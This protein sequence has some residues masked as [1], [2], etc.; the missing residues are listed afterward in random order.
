MALPGP[1]LGALAM[2]LL[3]LLLLTL[4]AGARLLWDKWK[5]RSLHLPPLVPGFLHLLQPN[6]PLYLLG[7]TQKLGPVYRLRLGLRGALAPSPP[8]QGEEGRIGVPSLL[9]SCFGHPPDVVVLNSKRT[10]EEAMIRK[11]VDFAGRPQTASCKC[12]GLVSR[13]DMGWWRQGMS[14]PWLPW[15]A[16]PLSYL[17]ISWCLSTSQTYPS[18]TTPCSG[19]LT[20]SLPAQPCCWASATPWSRWWSS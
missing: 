14:G 4:L 13:E 8:P 15:A 20:R 17:Q 1:L 16:Q 6:L 12:S 2:L 3:G 10:I 5:F 9:T 18:G 11:W 19:R 7:L